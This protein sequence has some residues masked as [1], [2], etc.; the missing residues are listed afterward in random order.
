MYLT[1]NY[2][3]VSQFGAVGDKFDPSLHDALLKIPKPEITAVDVENT[4]GQVLKPGYKLKD[5]VI[6]AAEVGILV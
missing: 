1:P 6:R 2:F 4:I 3:R 5:R